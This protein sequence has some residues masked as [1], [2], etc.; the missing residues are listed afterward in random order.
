MRLFGH[1]VHPML[2]A[3][4]LALLALAPVCD[5]A[6]WLGVAK[7]LAV[8]AYYL[9]LMGLIGGG[10]AALTGFVDFYRLDAPAN[11]ALSQSA[12][13][14]AACALGT[15]ALFGAA[16]AFRGDDAAA[17]TPGVIALEA[18]GAGLVAV[19]GWLGG[20]LVFR[21]GAGVDTRAPERPRGSH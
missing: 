14:H 5:A 8:V 17:P 11:G 21:F 18:L 6:V 2:V 16:F 19:T 13:A 7:R 20:H 3:F 9:E 1:P 10:L 15:L 12:L 4:P